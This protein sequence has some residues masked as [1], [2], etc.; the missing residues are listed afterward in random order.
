MTILMQ[1]LQ[2]MKDYVFFLSTKDI[3]HVDD[4]NE[5]DKLNIIYFRTNKFK[6]HL[7][8]QYCFLHFEDEDD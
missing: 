1:K 2:I 4:F 5:D 7:Q 3:F 6:N 8:F